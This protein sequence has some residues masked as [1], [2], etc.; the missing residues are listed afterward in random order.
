MEGL[1]VRQLKTTALTILK[2]LEFSSLLPS[3]LLQ[4]MILFIFLTFLFSGVGR[5]YG[6]VVL[7]IFFLLCYHPHIFKRGWM[8]YF[9]WYF[10]IAFKLGYFYPI[11]FLPVTLR[12]LTVRLL[13]WLREKITTHK[14]LGLDQRTYISAR[15]HR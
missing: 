7:R 15:Y 13:P 1:T 10:G 2:I 3:P 11:S 4:Y 8:V 9:M 14:T 12:R 6:G 5:L